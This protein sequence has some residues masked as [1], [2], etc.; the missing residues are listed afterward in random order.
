[1]NLNFYSVLFSLFISLFTRYIKE[2]EFQNTLP[3]ENYENMIKISN[4]GLNN[5]ADFAAVCN[6]TTTCAYFSNS[7]NNWVFEDNCHN[8]FFCLEQN[9]VRIQ[10]HK[11]Q[12]VKITGGKI[13]FKELL[14]WFICNTYLY[15][16]QS[17]YLSFQKKKV[18]AVCQWN[19]QGRCWIH[20]WIIL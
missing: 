5:F 12:S 18:L 15:K 10:Y 3:S 11:V 9:T 20:V 6:P 7:S 17:R 4:S 2:R 19:K 13:L 16:K 14:P 1:M 8:R